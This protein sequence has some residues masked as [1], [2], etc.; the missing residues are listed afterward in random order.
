MKTIKYKLKQFD[1]L[2][3]VLIDYNETNLEIAEKEAYNGDY[4]IE[5]DEEL[6]E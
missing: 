4:T 3:D 6:I 2:V 5:D 1:T